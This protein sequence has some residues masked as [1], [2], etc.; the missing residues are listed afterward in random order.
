MTEERLSFSSAP[1]DGNNKLF[2]D[3]WLCFYELHRGKS[4][5][6]D[7]WPSLHQNLIYLVTPNRATP[8]SASV[9]VGGR[10]S[11]EWTRYTDWHV[12]LVSMIARSQNRNSIRL[13]AQPLLGACTNLLFCQILTSCQ[14]ISGELVKGLPHLPMW[15]W[16]LLV[17]LGFK[18]IYLGY[19][20]V[21]TYIWKIASH[22]PTFQ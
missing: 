8:Y 1:L 4:H 19:V 22:M 12:I 15:T 16:V 13:I 21:F 2:L 7:A 18:G 20:F 10:Q 9:G 11:T 6:D 14:K 17:C 5:N 3:L